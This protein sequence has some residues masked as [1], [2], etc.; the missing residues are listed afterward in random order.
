[1]GLSPDGVLLSSE[2]TSR[3]AEVVFEFIRSSK[4]KKNLRIIQFNGRTILCRPFNN[5][6]EFEFQVKRSASLE[7]DLLR[8]SKMEMPKLVSVMK[9]LGSIRS[10]I[11]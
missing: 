7:T 11:E 6:V 4:L 2:E 1:M 9:M 3:D 10:I 5:T 8:K